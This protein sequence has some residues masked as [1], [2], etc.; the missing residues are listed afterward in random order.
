MRSRR[1]AGPQAPAPADPSGGGGHDPA[2]RG[3]QQS[4]PRLQQCGA[5]TLRVGPIAA[6]RESGGVDG[7]GD[8]ACGPA[9]ERPHPVQL[10][11]SLGRTRPST[12]CSAMIPRSMPRPGRRLDLIVVPQPPTRQPDPHPVL[13]SWRERGWV[14]PDGTPGAPDRLITGD[15]ARVQ[16][17]RPG[18][19][20]LYANRQGGFRVACPSCGANLV[21]P[22]MA[23]ITSWRAGGPRE[24]ACS[25]CTRSHP[26]ETLDF[27][28]AAAFGMCAVVFFDVGS[29]ALLPAAVAEL[30]EAIGPGCT[31]LRRA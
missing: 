13:D 19:M 16:V 6:P 5:R 8:H 11:P 1:G 17:D 28:P 7:G 2:R 27:K 14:R 20:T 29:A 18:R 9:G 26:L 10:V 12:S 24:C 21:P 4:G 3:R 25:A 23:A 30:T 15:F 22:F 31:V